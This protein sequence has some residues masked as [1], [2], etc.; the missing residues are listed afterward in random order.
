[1]PYIILFIYNANKTMVLKVKI[2]VAFK[3]R[4]YERDKKE[5]SRMIEIFC[6]LMCVVHRLIDFMIIQAVYFSL[7]YTFKN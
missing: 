1:M 4:N 3:V 6:F 7:C 5:T 2:V